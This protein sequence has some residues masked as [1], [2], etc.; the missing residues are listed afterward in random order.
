MALIL[1]LSSSYRRIFFI[2]HCSPHCGTS[3]QVQGVY[4]ETAFRR[5][6]DYEEGRFVALILPLSNFF[7]KIF[8]IKKL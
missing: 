2:G 4:R 8:C 5:G 7:V 6:H 1:P 3:F